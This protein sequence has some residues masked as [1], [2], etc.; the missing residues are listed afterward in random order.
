M[1]DRFIGVVL[2]A[3]DTAHVGQHQDRHEQRVVPQLA[4]VERIGRDVL[5]AAFLCFGKAVHDP[6]GPLFAH[7]AVSLVA[8]VFIQIG[9]RQDGRHGVDVFA[10]QAVCDARVVIFPQRRQIPPVFRALEQ[11][12]QAVQAHALRP[13]PKLVL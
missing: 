6:L 12:P 4:V 11:L 2:P 9:Q 3:Q 10:G 5:K 7:R 1:I 8:G 13:L